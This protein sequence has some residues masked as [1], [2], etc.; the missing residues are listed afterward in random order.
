MR[1]ILICGHKDKYLESSC[2]LLARFMIGVG[3]GGVDV[4]TEGELGRINNTKKI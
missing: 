4:N 1:A 2:E 3:W